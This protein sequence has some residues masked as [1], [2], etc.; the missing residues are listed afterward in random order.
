MKTENEILI[1]S[2]DMMNMAEEMYK[3]GLYG[4]PNFYE[5]G[6]ILGFIDALMWITGDGNEFR[7]WLDTSFGEELWKE[8]GYGDDDEL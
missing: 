2:N 8:L 5:F 1:L 7:E 3:N 4:V 6:R